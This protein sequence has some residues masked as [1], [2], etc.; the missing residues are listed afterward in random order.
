M[1][2]TNISIRML[3]HENTQR[4]SDDI[5]GSTV[6]ALLNELRGARVHKRQAVRAGGHVGG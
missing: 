5:L 3:V 2:D 1:P 4:K 6:P